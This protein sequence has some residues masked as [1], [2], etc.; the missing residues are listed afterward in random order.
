MKTTLITD[1]VTV[2]DNHTDSVLPDDAKVYRC[3]VPHHKNLYL[4][5]DAGTVY[6]AHPLSSKDK[7]RLYVGIDRVKPITWD[8]VHEASEDMLNTYEVYE[9]S[10]LDREIQDG[11]KGVPPMRPAFVTTLHLRDGANN[12]VEFMTQTWGLL[13]RGYPLCVV[14]HKKGDVRYVLDATPESTRLYDGP[15]IQEALKAYVNHKSK[16]A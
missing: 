16:Q 1:P 11:L 2:R 6:F 13:E 12:F 5:D 3:E 4:V 15:S 7:T 9:P 8:R 10:R 14:A